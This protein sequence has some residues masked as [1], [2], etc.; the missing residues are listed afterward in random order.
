MQLDEILL[1][2]KAARRTWRRNDDQSI[3]DIGITK[4]MNGARIFERYREAR[5]ILA[6]DAARNTQRPRRCCRDV[7]DVDDP[8]RAIGFH[9]GHA[10]PCEL[11]ANDRRAVVRSIKN[12]LAQAI[13]AVTT[14]R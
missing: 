3:A 10:R 12:R 6:G 4:F 11:D 5:A 13:I 9:T 1:L 7:R 14:Q 8:A 2:K